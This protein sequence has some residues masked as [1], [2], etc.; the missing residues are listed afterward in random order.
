MGLLEEWSDK[1]IEIIM[2]LG[3]LDRIRLIAQPRFPP[4]FVSEDSFLKLQEES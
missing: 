2:G 4:S 1:S 3:A